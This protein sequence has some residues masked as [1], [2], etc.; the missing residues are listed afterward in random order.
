MAVTGACWVLTL[1]LMVVTSEGKN[2]VF[3]PMEAT[4]HA[5]IHAFV[6]VELAKMGHHVWVA[7]S[8]ALHKGNVEKY[9]GVTTFTYNTYSE[10][11][12]DKLIAD[13]ETT[14]YNAITNG[15]DP[16]WAWL[17]L[18]QS[19]VSNTYFK[20]M[21]RGHLI[22]YIDSLKPDLIVL[23]GFPDVDERVAISYK[24]KVP[25]ALVTTLFAQTPI[26]MPLNPT[27]EAYNNRYI[28]TEA[29]FFETIIAVMKVMSLRIVH[30]FNDRGYMKQLFPTDPDVPA[31]NE[32]FSQ[33]EVY[34]IESDPLNDYPRPAPPNVKLIGGICAGPPQELKEPFKSF[35]ARS[36]KAGVGVALLSFGSLCMN[37]PKEG[38]RKIIAALKRL[39]LNTIWRANISSPDPGK[40]LTSTWLPQNDLLGNKNV[41]VF[42][43]HAG[44]HSIYEALYHAVPTVCVP[45][46]YDQQYNADR[47]ED[48]G[49]CI[50]IDIIKASEDELVSVIE[51]VLS[52]K[53]MKATVSK[54]SA[55]Y[56]ELY[57]NPKQEAAYWLDHVMRHGGEYMRESGQKIPMVLYIL[58]YIIVFL[59]GVISTI[60]VFLIVHLLKLLSRFSLRS[61][62]HVK[63]E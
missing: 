8:E 19:H 53:E 31:A 33:A 9:P 60:L 1:F 32:L 14:I 10:L 38:E 12:E 21:S 16:D 37:L 26:R 56:R 13:I 58:D 34:L 43:S 51:R 20:A 25:F 46:F 29:N 22:E 4:S 47:A 42:I 45:L 11:S 49:H 48:K 24:L 59:V 57:K 2:V 35:I 5:R 54:A 30:L 28:R 62:E 6:A 39:N 27:A 55:I 63:N 15:T 36:E 3:L 17:K 40:I 18:L 41:K 52:S 61:D 44:A 7:L 50:S 23:E